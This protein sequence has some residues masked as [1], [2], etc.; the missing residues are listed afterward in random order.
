MVAAAAH[1]ASQ[2]PYENLQIAHQQPVFQLHIRRQRQ[3]QDV[4]IA[5]RHRLRLPLGV[6]Q[7]L[8]AETQVALRRHQL[9]A[10]PH[11]EAVLHP[12]LGQLAT[13]LAGQ[14]TDELLTF[15]DRA[16]ALVVLVFVMYMAA[17]EALGVATMRQ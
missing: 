4:A 8:Q 6:L 2:P 13:A 1:R 15:G 12:H 3:I 17:Q 5:R 10:I 9:Q 14:F 7:V 11:G 16:A